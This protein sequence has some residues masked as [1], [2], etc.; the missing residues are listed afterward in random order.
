MEIVFRSFESTIE[1]FLDLGVGFYRL[2]YLFFWENDAFW[3]L[4]FTSI[5]INYYNFASGT[6][7]TA[8]SWNL[9]TLLF[10]FGIT[11]GI[12]A[13]VWRWIKGIILG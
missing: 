8:F 12:A 6:V 4:L 9:V 7:E 2:A 1:W 10:S 11:M 3:A 5:D 13:W